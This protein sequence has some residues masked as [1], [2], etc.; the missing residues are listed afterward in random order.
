VSETD[1]LKRFL[2]S[3]V[4]DYEKWHD[5]IGYDLEALGA[6]KG[7]DKAQ[8]I[9]WL[10]SRLCDRDAGW[11]DAEAAQYLGQADLIEIARRHRNAEVRRVVASKAD[12]RRDILSAL[13]K[14]E[15]DSETLR[16]LDDI[17]LT[18]DPEM[19]ATLLWCTLHSPGV[20]AFHAAA[21]LLEI[22]TGLQDPWDERPF[23]L[24]FTEPETRQP[25]YA[26]LLKR[27]D[28]IR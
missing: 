13:R 12:R 21:K 19:R 9:A 26:E 11:R 10:K 7:T 17:A 15:D 4:M 22:Y 6:L 8:A 2:D 1:S 14:G 20:V 18:P 5:G 3:T 28:G 23:L 16:A 27:I 25:A 24:Q